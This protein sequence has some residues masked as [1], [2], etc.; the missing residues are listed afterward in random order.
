MR[1]VFAKVQ[2]VTGLDQAAHRQE[3]L[4]HIDKLEAHDQR[5]FVAQFGDDVGPF[6]AK[7]Y[8]HSAVGN[9]VF[10][11]HHRG[12]EQR[13]AARHVWG[14]TTVSEA[15]LSPVKTILSHSGG[16]ASALMA[17]VAKRPQRLDEKTSWPTV[18]G[19]SGSKSRNP[20]IPPEK[21]RPAQ[22]MLSHTSGTNGKSHSVCT[23]GRVLLTNAQEQRPRLQSNRDW[24][25]NGLYFDHSKLQLRRLTYTRRKQN[26]REQTGW[27]LGGKSNADSSASC[28]LAYWRLLV[29]TLQTYLS[30]Y[31]P[32]TQNLQI[33]YF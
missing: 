20:Q 13:Q 17:F 14:G 16:A 19:I 5:C 33:G 10:S 32:S 6:L 1:I 12:V 4:V 21:Q 3:R 25:Y 23:Q 15:P 11:T 31:L 29:A 30:Q 28:E 8:N 24:E 9:L 27:T 26:D 18:I 22:W 7:V 2:F